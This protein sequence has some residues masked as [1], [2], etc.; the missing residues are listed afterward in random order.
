V[1]LTSPAPATSSEF[2][3]ALSAAVGRRDRPWL[4]V[5]ALALRLG[6]G[7]AASE[8]LNSARVTP[9]RLLEAGYEFRHPTVAAALTG[10][11]TPR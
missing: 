5:P 7:E 6:L 2:T 11:L 4:R 9:T 3:A 8:L 10:E 1:N